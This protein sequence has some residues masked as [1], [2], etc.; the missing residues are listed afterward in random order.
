MLV[1]HIN[2]SPMGKLAIQLMQISRPIPAG[3][4]FGWC[5]RGGWCGGGGR[6]VVSDLNQIGRNIGRNGHF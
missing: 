6:G 2:N 1:R 4:R 5:G 3:I